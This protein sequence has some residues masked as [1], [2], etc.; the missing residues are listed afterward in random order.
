M[1]NHGRFRF[2]SPASS[3]VTQIYAPVVSGNIPTTLCGSEDENENSTDSG[4]PASLLATE[5]LRVPS[6]DEDTL[7]VVYSRS[8]TTAVE[9]LLAVQAIQNHPKVPQLSTPRTSW[10][11]TL[12]QV[13]S[14]FG[15]RRRGPTPK[16]RQRSMSYPIPRTIVALNTPVRGEEPQHPTQPIDIPN[17]HFDFY[18]DTEVVFQHHIGSGPNHPTIG[19]AV[20]APDVFTPEVVQRG[21][22]VPA[23]RR[24]VSVPHPPAA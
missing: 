22:H 14:I 12:H 4:P 3:I 19:L 21:F 20:V 13:V 23:R 2:V 18:E 15:G 1:A 11:P 7:V 24:A 10:M 5:P 16:A 8:T 17:L 9:N 6:R